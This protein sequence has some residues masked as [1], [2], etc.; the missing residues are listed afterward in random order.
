MTDFATLTTVLPVINHVPSLSVGLMYT[1]AVTTPDVLDIGVVDG[2]LKDYVSGVVGTG[3]GRVTGTVKETGSPNTPVHRKVRLIRERDGLLMREVWSHPITGGY[4]FDYVDELQKFT[5]LSY[6]HT[7][8]F[9]AVVA[10]GQVP[11]LI[12]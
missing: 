1:G 10:D 11:E 3:R 5:V 9:R 7:G 8:A 6:D 4:S 2:G 12:P